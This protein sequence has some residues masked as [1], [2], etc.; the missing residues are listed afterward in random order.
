MRNSLLIQVVY[1]DLAGHEQVEGGGEKHLKNVKLVTRAFQPSIQRIENP[2]DDRLLL[3][4]W[5]NDRNIAQDSSVD[6]WHDT[7]NRVCLQMVLRLLRT[8]KVAEIQ[9][10]NMLKRW[11]NY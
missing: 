7:A 2:G 6:V 4:R 1:P 3:S 5:K 10:E 8:E 11:S 9:W